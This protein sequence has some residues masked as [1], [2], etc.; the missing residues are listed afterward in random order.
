M[1]SKRWIMPLKVAS[2]LTLA[3]VIA[4]AFGWNKPYWAAFAV[5]VMAATETNGHSLKKGRLRLL[6]TCAGVVIA[7]ILV[8][9][10]GQQPL[11]FF[12]C[13]FDHHRYLYL[14]AE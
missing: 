7:F 14:S 13:L 4:L 1:I 2:A 10:F 5:I 3:I 12:S 9:L 11:A 6:G 8:S